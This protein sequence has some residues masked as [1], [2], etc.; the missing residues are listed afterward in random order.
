[1]STRKAVSCTNK[2]RRLCGGN[3]RT[4]T[5][6]LLP[7][8]LPPRSKDLRSDSNK[9]QRPRLQLQPRSNIQPHPHPHPLPATQLHRRDAQRDR[10]R[11]PNIPHPVGEEWRS[12]RPPQSQ[13]SPRCRTA[14]LRCSAVTLHQLHPLHPL[15]TPCWNSSGAQRPCCNNPQRSSRQ[16]LHFADP[17]LHRR[18]LGHKNQHLLHHA[19]PEWTRAASRKLLH[20]H[21]PHNVCEA[22]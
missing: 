5:T 2:H 21:H 1:M 3:L 4:R 22:S 17:H 11:N 19:K 13:S 15:P 8:P 20:P 12:R 18:N 6:S 16:Q 10:P 9:L 7:L 14:E